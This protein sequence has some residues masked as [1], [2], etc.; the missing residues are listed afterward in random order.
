VVRK[1]LFCRFYPG[2]LPRKVDIHQ[3]EIGHFAVSHRDSLFTGGC[4]SHDPVPERPEGLLQVQRGD[5]LVFNDQDRFLLHSH[6][7]SKHR[8]RVLI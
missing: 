3:D 6:L 5:L 2:H 7:L 8:D 4:C 1:D